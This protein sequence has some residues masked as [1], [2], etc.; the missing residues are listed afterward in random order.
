MEGIELSSYNTSTMATIGILGTGDYGRA[1]AKRM[2][3]CGLKVVFGSRDP[4]SRHLEAIDKELA[5]AKLS[6]V[7]DV[8]SNENIE[9]IILAVH[10]WNID[11]CLENFNAESSQKIFIDISNNE[12]ILKDESIAE[13]LVAKFPGMRVVKAFNT[14][15]AYAVEDDNFGGS[16]RVLIAAD[17]IEAREKVSWLCSEIGFESV[18]YGSLKAARE[19]EAYPTRLMQGWGKATIF[20]LIVFFAWNIFVGV[21]YVYYYSK[22]NKRFPWETIPLRFINKSICMTA[23]TL[24]TFSYLPGCLAAF[25]QI[26]NG[27]K[28]I[29][30]PNFLDLW[31][32]SRKMLGLYALL[33]SLWHVII[34]TICMSPGYWGGWFQSTRITLPE[35][36]TDLT[37]SFS[38]RMNFQG[39]ANISAGILAILCMIIVGLSSLPS[40]GNI[41]NWREWRF[42]QSH[43]GYITLLF[44]TA[45]VLIFSFPYWIRRPSGLWKSSTFLSCLIPMIT[46]CLKF[47]LLLPCIG[48]YVYKIRSGWERKKSSKS[49]LTTICL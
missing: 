13:T 10:H 45:H 4:A 7:K 46:L 42:V 5:D 39:E 48:N 44:A 41:L 30:F 16:R 49:L 24:L 27:S 3:R 18:T 6:T 28:Y 2:L 29:R 1:L 38:S 37:L 34:S 33:F 15:S 20:M 22:Y 8:L 23:I 40:V 9:I 43:L 25:L 35:N 11:S 36:T 32:K 12:E 21:K 26:Y 47:L 31:L 17:D 14:L 19:L